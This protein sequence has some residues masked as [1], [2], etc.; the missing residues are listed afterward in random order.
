MNGCKRSDCFEFDNDRIFNKEIDAILIAKIVAFVARR[1]CELAMEVKPAR[2]ELNREGCLI[3]RLKESDA[4]FGV[5]LDGGTNDD[6]RAFILIHLCVLSF[7]FAPLRLTVDVRQSSR[8]GL[9][10]EVV[11]KMIQR[12]Q[13]R[14]RRH[15][16]ECA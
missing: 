16:A 12:R 6:F 5:N 11:G 4:K 3:G 2:S 9:Q 7:P 8:A 14:E 15:A 10:P 13:H 1:Q